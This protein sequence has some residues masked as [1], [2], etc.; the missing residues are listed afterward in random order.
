MTEI[1]HAAPSGEPIDLVSELISSRDRLEQ[2]CR[3]GEWG[4]ELRAR[5]WREQQTFLY[6]DTNHDIGPL[7]DEVAAYKRVCRALQSEKAE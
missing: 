5:A 6:A 2:L 3:L 4:L 7:A 1:T